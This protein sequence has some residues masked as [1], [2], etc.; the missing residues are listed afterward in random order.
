MALKPIVGFCSSKYIIDV[1]ASLY[2]VERNK[3][4]SLGSIVT[5]DIL[6]KSLREKAK[7]SFYKK[8]PELVD[9]KLY[10]W[11]PT[12]RGS[13]ANI[14]LN[15]IP[16]LEE[17]SHLLKKDEILL[18]K[19]HPSIVDI[20]TISSK[21]S[22]ISNII[23]VT[24]QDLFELLSVTSVFMT[25]YSSTLHYAMLMKIP[26]AFLLND[27]DNYSVDQGLLIDIKDFCG[28]VLT[29]FNSK[30]IL[31]ILRNP[32]LPSSAKYKKFLMFHC[33]ACV[34]GNCKRK[35]FEEIIMN[36]KSIINI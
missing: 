3:V 25:D 20:S 12:F 13:G 26:V 15:Q 16:N 6:D 7:E 19:F 36:I 18:C 5:D 33:E 28:P 34:E 10:L 17:I 11:C 31:N 29:N 14:H 22:N 9:K 23:D 27:Y 1:Y 35:I 8:F 2:G 21:L 32:E 24:K 4:K 30:E